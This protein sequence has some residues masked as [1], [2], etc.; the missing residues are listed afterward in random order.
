M[1]LDT[2]IYSGYEVPPYYDAMLAKLVVWDRTREDAINR[3]LRCLSEFELEGIKTNIEYQIKILSNP[4]FKKAKYQQ[5]SY[6]RE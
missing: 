2:H 6:R 5:A 3:M 4:Y 1:R